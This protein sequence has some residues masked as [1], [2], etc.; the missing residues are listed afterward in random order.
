PRHRPALGVPGPCQGKRHLLVSDGRA[1]A[2]RPGRRA[3]RA[4][5]RRASWGGPMTPTFDN[6]IQGFFCC[7][8]IEQQGASRRTVEAYRDTFRLLLDYLPGRLGKAI[9][10][11]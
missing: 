6:L 5:R 7:R 11:L 8:L 1:R 10:G 3:L 9:S 2:V 4:L